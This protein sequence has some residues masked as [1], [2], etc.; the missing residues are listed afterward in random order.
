MQTHAGYQASGRET[1]VANP[2]RTDR[3]PRR[4][5]SLWALV[6]AAL[7]GILIVPLPLGTVPGPVQFEV[8]AGDSLEVIAGAQYHAGAIHRMLLGSHYREIWTTPI[9]VPVL[10]VEQYAGGL[11][12]FR[13]GGGAQTRT[14][15]LRSASGH[16][17]VFRSTAK[18]V[19][20]LPNFLHGSLLGR[21]LQDGISRAHPGGA[22]I[23]VALQEAIGFPSNPLQL[24]V[25]AGDSGLGPYRA[26]YQGLLGTLQEEPADSDPFHPRSSEEMLAALDSSTQNRVTATDFLA[27]RLLDFILNDWDRHP[28]QWGWRPEPRESRTVFHPIPKDRDQAFAWY[29]G[30]VADLVRLVKPKLVK[31]GP[32]FPSLSG[33]TH[34][35]RRLDRQLL[36][37]L[38]AEEWNTVT[39]FVQQQLADSVLDQAVRRLPGPWY[40]LSGPML[41]EALRQ[42]RDSLAGISRRFFDLVH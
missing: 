29:D 25:L 9:R 28:G 1:T 21:V 40:R 17:F 4:P 12:A 30:A 26:R 36:P 42:R 2:G 11:R 27:A 20:V 24:G 8:P 7:L 5:S 41:M 22:L 38:T 16:Q 31:F 37:P 32:G 13:E 23:A 34:N 6:P 14:L 19:R 18:V 10:R 3:R 15:H 33:L 35:S 39:R